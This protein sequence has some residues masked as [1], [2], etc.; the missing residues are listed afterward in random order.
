MSKIVVGGK[1]YNET[2]FEKSIDLVFKICQKSI[3]WN[4]LGVVTIRT[5]LAENTIKEMNDDLNKLYLTD[6]HYRY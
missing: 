4:S 6:R 2:Y 1:S 3:D 5:T